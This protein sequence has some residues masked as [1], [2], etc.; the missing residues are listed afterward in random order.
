[1]CIQK[2]A[3]KIPPYITSVPLPEL[4]LCLF[5]CGWQLMLIC[6]ERKVLLTGCWLVAGADLV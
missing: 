5:G 4:N 3:N 6:Y 2:R 1:M